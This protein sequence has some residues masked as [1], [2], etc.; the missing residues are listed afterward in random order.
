[1]SIFDDGNDFWQGTE[2]WLIGE[3]ATRY[4][5]SE[6]MATGNL[7]DWTAI[8]QVHKIK[9]STLV[10]NG[11][12]DE[13]QDLAVMPFFERISKVKWITS[14]KSSH[15]GH[16]EERK[17]YMEILGQFLKSKNWFWML[18]YLL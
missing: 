10:I 8:D 9:A 17:R 4:G 7:K 13:V 15:M 2:L 12:H 6:L 5:P 11:Q 1:M 14:E 16:F 3:N 18:P